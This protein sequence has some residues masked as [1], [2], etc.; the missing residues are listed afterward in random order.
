M[1]N[2]KRRREEEDRA[3]FEGDTLSK[4]RMINA[5]DDNE[6]YMMDKAMELV[7]NGIV[8]IP[9]MSETKTIKVVNELEKCIQGAPDT[10]DFF[11]KNGYKSL[12]ENHRL[13]FGSFGAL[14]SVTGYYNQVSRGVLCDMINYLDPFYKHVSNLTNTT[15]IRHVHDRLLI[16]SPGLKIPGNSWHRDVHPDKSSYTFGGWV[17]LK[18]VQKFS[19]V[20][21]SHLS[22]EQYSNL[23]DEKNGHK[24]P[25]PVGFQ[26]EPKY[27]TAEQ[28]SKQKTVTV[29]P[30]H[31]VIFYSHI[32][33]EIIKSVFDDVV[34]RIFAGFS[35]S[36]DPSSIHEGFVEE[37]QRRCKLQIPQLLPSAQEPRQVP[38]NYYPIHMEK[39]E[40][41]SKDF[42][43]SVTIIKTLPKDAKTIKYAGMPVKVLRDIAKGFDKLYHKESTSAEI[44]RLGYVQITRIAK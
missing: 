36:N 27:L 40:K 32:L 11:V 3:E 41:M 22:P 33:H 31:I 17:S 12:D 21:D 6:N 29:P 18:M 34:V 15:F 42:P 8:V 37:Q 44:E 28:K 2:L 16:R 19:Y 35:L 9:F 23:Y 1:D 4:K 43:E 26:V 24:Q 10:P 20:A 39:L 30:G 7:T 5:D 25:V 38:R 14:G 13:V